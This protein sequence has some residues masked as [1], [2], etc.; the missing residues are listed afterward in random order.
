[1][2]VGVTQLIKAYLRFIAIL[3]NVHISI[4]AENNQRDSVNT[5][6]STWVMWGQKQHRAR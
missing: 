4:S 3:R 2:L 1:M 6:E 5:Y